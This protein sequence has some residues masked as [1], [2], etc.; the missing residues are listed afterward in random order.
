MSFE[1]KFSNFTAQNLSPEDR[2]RY[3]KLGKAMYENID[4]EKTHVVSNSADLI[5]DGK[6]ILD[7]A[8]EGLKSGLHP[9]ELDEYA[10]A[11]LKD[12]YG[13]RWYKIFHYKASDIR[14]DIRDKTDNTNDNLDPDI[15]SPFGTMDE[16][17]EE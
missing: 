1:E 7:Y 12:T 17:Q 3:K 13:L 10:I 14:E 4:F 2:E 9:N 8:T 15:R 11:S 5:I 16:D 6:E